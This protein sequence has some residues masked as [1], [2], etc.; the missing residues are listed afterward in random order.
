MRILVPVTAIG[1]LG[2]V[3]QADLGT[4]AGVSFEAFRA[5]ASA[6]RE[7]GTGAYIVDGDIVLHGDAALRRYWERA[8]P[9]ALT[10]YNLEG[11]DVK[12]SDGDK[13]NLTYCVSDGFGADKAAVI[14]AMKEATENGW[15]KFASVR[16]VHVAAQD[17]TCTAFNQNV[18]FD[19]R[20]VDSGGQYLARAFFPDDQRGQRNVLVDGDSFD[21]IWPLSNILGHE[22]G[23]ALGFR[24]EHVRAPGDP[25]PEG[26]DFRAITPYDAA[27][28]MHYPQCGGTSQ[29]L[30]FTTFDQQG[31]AMVYGEPAPPNLPP[32]AAINTPK[33]GDIVPSSFEVQ[34]SLIDMDLARGELFVDGKLYQTLTAGPYTF[35][36]RDLAPGFHDLIVKATD[37]ANQATERRIRV[38]VLK[39]EDGDDGIDDDRDPGNDDAGCNAGGASTGAGV[40]VALGLIGVL[41]R[42]RRR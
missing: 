23:H 36:V 11:V 32:M 20:P 21:T 27:S 8:Q 37:S 17:A 4:T 25:C 30:A 14:A 39:P 24:H 41:R 40:L 16:F 2:C 1:L 12:W 19:V 6:H 26:T 34:T 10:I 15:E 13:L 9:G 29:T 18:V 5:A 31:A 7:P 22:L 28:I 33:D 3:Q 35:Q 38:G 42:R